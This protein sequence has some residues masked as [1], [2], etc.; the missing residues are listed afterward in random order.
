MLMINCQVSNVANCIKIAMDFVSDV[1]I[2]R[3]LE[4]AEERRRLEPDTHIKEDMLRVKE[5]LWYA[6]VY[7]RQRNCFEPV[8][9]DAMRKENDK[10]RKG[11]HQRFQRRKRAKKAMDAAGDDTI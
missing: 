6:Y 1:E 10:A 9:K 4:L 5:M 3:C 2:A 11:Q 8:D 7:L